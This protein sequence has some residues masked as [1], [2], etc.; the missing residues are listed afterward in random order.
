MDIQLH[1]LFLQYAH[2]PSLWIDDSY[3]GKLA[4]LFPAKLL[5]QAWRKD[6]FSALLEQ[7]LELGDGGEMH[8]DELQQVEAAQMMVLDGLKLKQLATCI[9]ICFIS[10]DL[11]IMID[12][13]KIDN[14]TADFGPDAVGFARSGEAGQCLLDAEQETTKVPHS[15]YSRDR[16][17]TI[18]QGFGVIKT[19][20][21][22]LGA[23]WHKRFAYK[24]PKQI[25]ER[26]EQQ[27]ALP[28]DF[29]KKLLL[30]IIT[31]QFGEQQPWLQ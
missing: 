3:R 4:T 10:D 12:K 28:E 17:A 9:G 11:R 14:A 22:Q 8:T 24:M 1:K 31:L 25:G 13:Q 18:G 5:E 7:H 20:G 29:C 30:L 15:R 2:N 23:A 21:Q 6:H 19:A 16:Y 26:L 27:E